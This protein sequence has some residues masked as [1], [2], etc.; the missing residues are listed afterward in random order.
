[1]QGEALQVLGAAIRRGL[2]SIPQECV[3]FVL[4]RTAANQDV[5][6]WKYLQCYMTDPMDT[7]PRSKIFSNCVAHFCKR[8]MPSIY[9]F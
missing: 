9:Y 8:C 7:K 4:P 2:R 3:A 5:I 6:E 1:M